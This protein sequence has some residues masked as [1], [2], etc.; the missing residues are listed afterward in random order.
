MNF[1]EAL[2]AMKEGH[3]VKRQHWSGYWE[4]VPRKDEQSTILMH[5]WDGK[6]IDIFDTDRPEYTLNNIAAEDFEIVE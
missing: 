1:A 6:I 5:T 4:Y 3:K 2:K